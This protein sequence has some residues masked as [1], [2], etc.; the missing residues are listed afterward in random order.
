MLKEREGWN[1]VVRGG[2]I[3]GLSQFKSS[4]AALDLL[5]P[6]TELGVPQALR[7]VAIRALG[8]ISLNQEKPAI[9]RILDRLEAL[10]REEFFLTQIATV[11]ALSQMEV[12][13]AVAILRG[14]A[15]HSPDG[16]VKR[17]ADEAAQKV[18]KKIGSDQAI[19]DLRQELDEVKQTNKDLKSRPENLEAKT[20]S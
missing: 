16:R 6:Y 12:R 14:L 13:G 1:E 10:S 3:A 11:G 20:K 19:A 9:E 7:L 17:R 15:D 4:A 2:A 18:Q 5:L 8:S